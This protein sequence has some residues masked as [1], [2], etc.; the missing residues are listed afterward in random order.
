MAAPSK[1][2]IIG[3]GIGG[4][5]AALALL[6]RGIDVEVYEQSPV[7]FETGEVVS[8]A[9]LVG[10]D[11]IRS[12]VRQCLFGADRAQFTGCVA[13]RGL[14]PFERLPPGVSRTLGTNWL[15]PRGHV[16]HYPVRRG[17]LMNFISLVERDDWQIESW[18]VA[19]T[20]SE[21]ADDYRG[22][23]D[24]AHAIIRHIKTTFKWTLLV[25]GT[26]QHSS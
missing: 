16:L 21:L 23:H 6:R 7:R 13:W 3:G 18:T 9:L 2:V 25:R 1:I 19:G 22:W 11:G 12:Q 20:T 5:T 17:E 8:A 26:T 4:L 10:A 14:V 15:G 24:D